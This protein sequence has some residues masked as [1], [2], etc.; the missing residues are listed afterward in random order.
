MYLAKQE[1]NVFLLHSKKISCKKD[2]AKGQR[3]IVSADWNKLSSPIRKGTNTLV[4]VHIFLG[5][6]V[7][8]LRVKGKRMRLFIQSRPN[9]L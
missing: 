3:Q 7:D 5:H 6:A 8:N 9:D 2:N 1:K 4:L